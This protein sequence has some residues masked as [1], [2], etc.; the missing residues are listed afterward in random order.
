VWIKEV[1]LIVR[2]FKLQCQIT[3]T[4]KFD[5]ESAMCWICL[6]CAGLYVIAGIW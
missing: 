5:V 4:V 3:V 2:R 6:L 1:L